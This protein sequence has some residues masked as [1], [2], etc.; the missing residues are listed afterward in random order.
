MADVSVSMETVDGVSYRRHR[1]EDD[2][3]G[4]TNAAKR[5]DARERLRCSTRLSQD[6]TLISRH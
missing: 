3:H 5:R 4:C 1:P 2:V 6:T